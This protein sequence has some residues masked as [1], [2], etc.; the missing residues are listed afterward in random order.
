MADVWSLQ[1][2]ADHIS[3]FM[4]HVACRGRLNVLVSHRSQN[5][6]VDGPRHVGPFCV[7]PQV[8][9]PGVHVHLEVLSIDSDDGSVDLSSDVCEVEWVAWVYDGVVAHNYPHCARAGSRLISAYDRK[10]HGRC[11]SCIGSDGG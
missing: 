7:N 6:C 9:R 10:C 11:K 2:E 1:R 8:A 4:M 3:I 5:P